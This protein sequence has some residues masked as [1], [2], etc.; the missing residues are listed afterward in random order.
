MIYERTTMDTVS[1][2]NEP[3]LEIKELGIYEQMKE[4]R[5]VLTEVLFTL[6]QFK[7]EIGNYDIPKDERALEPTC[8]K[9]EVSQ[10]KMLA[11]AIRG[12]L[13]RLMDEFH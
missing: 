12:D 9:E 2:C 13:G 4:T 1:T 8:F 10:I 7:R 5:E 11:F 3:K 6:D